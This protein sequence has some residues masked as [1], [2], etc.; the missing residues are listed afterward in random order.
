VNNSTLQLSLTPPIYRFDKSAQATTSLTPGGTTTF[1]LRVMWLNQRNQT[2]PWHHLIH[3][4]QETLTAGLFTLTGILSIGEGY[5]LHQATRKTGW[6]Y[7]TRFR[8]SFSE[9]P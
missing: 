2:V 1:P 4:D 7:L 6:V 9:F 3:L 8:K 5:L